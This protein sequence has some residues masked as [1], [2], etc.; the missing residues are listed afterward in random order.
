ME[1]EEDWRVQSENFKNL[2][3]DAFQKGETQ[4]A[5][6][7]Y[8]R[9][10]DLDPENHVFYSNR[11]A[12]YMKHDSISKALK[13]AEKCVELAPTW[14]K[15]YNRLGAAQQGLKR[16]EAAIES[17]KKSIELDSNNQSLWSA[18]TACKDAYE[19][20]KSAK[21]AQAAIERAQEEERL[22]RLNEIKQ[23]VAKEKKLQQEE[24]ELASFLDEV[25]EKKEEEP[26]KESEDDLL[27]GFFTEVLK[28]KEEPKDTENSKDPAKPSEPKDEKLL[29][30]KY[31]NAELG[32]GPEQVARILSS[33][34]TWKNLNPYYVLQ[35]D[36]DATEEDIKYRYKKLSA[37]VHPDK[38]IGIENA[39][40]AFEEVKNAYNKLLDEDQKKVIILN[41]ENIKNEV[42]QARRKL[43]SKGTKESTLPN[44]EDEITKKTMKA[45]ADME[46][47]RRRSE[48]NARS[49]SQ[50]EKNQAVEQHEKLKSDFKEE[51][52]WNDIDRREKRVGNWRDFA[53]T[54]KKA[55]VSAYTVEQR[56]FATHGKVFVDGKSHKI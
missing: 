10:I 41:I 14:S 13:D 18:L 48:N 32:S 54:E 30:A 35:L 38:L 22:K 23:E 7:Y 8:S 21:F 27:A 31:M 50:R 47:A 6:D 4:E 33:N 5:I 29:T 34:Y 39:R 56:D 36:I 1:G 43:I 52:A 51:E 55:K 16:F 11:S 12:A 9:A 45:F 42:K 25:S 40:D 19:A 2:G 17:F 26:P 49:Y 3:N 44:L 28:P 53:K 46:M 20:D 24:S 37:K 15:G